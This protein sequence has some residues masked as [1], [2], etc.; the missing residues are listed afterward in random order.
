[1]YVRVKDK[2]TGDEFDA[3]ESNPKIGDRLTPVNKKEYPLSPYPRAAKH[4]PL[5]STVKSV[6]VKPEKEVK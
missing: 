3:L 1:M 6:P 4:N 2:V 5:P